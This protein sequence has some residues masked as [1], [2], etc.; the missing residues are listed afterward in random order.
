MQNIKY[1]PN[2]VRIKPHQA[3]MIT[4][5]NTDSVNHSFVIS[6]VAE[7]IHL[8]VSPDRRIATSLFFEY[9]GVFQF[10]CSQ[11]GHKAAGMV[12]RIVVE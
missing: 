3:L 10:E 12:G 2:I 6:N 4:F 5:V 1:T 8:F 11:E 7:P 9:P